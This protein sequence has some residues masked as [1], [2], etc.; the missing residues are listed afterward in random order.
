MT[1]EEKFFGSVVS[2]SA[3]KGYGFI[4]WFKGS[5]KQADMF[6]HFSDI[7]CEGFKTLTK[8]QKVSFG[9]GKN[10]NGRPKATSVVVLVD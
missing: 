7:N 8:G 4:E 1:S 6:V 9:I 5:T 2:F 3:K 10:N